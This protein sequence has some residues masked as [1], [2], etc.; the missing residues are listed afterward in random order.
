VNCIL[1]VDIGTTSTKA[2][3]VHADGNVP[4]SYQVHHETQYPSPGYAEQDPAE[5]FKAV[6]TAIATVMKASNSKVTG[7]SFSCA[8]HGIMAVNAQGQ[9]LTPLI[10]WSDTRSTPQCKHIKADPLAVDIY[11]STGTPIHP[12]SPLC[13]VRWMSEQQPHLF[14]SSIKFVSAKEYIFYHL[15]GTW[16]IDYAVASATGLFDVHRLQWSPLAIAAARTSEAQ[17]STPIS[18]YQQFFLTSSAMAQELQV[19]IDTR[20]VIGASDGCLANWGSDVMSDDTL[21]ITIGT[22]G[23]VRTTSPHFRHDA[24]QRIFNYRLDEKH[25]VMGGATNN[26]SVLLNWFSQLFPSPEPLAERIAKAIAISPGADD[27]L[28]LPYV[29]GE[30]APIYEPYARGVFFGL[31]QHHSPDH[32]LRAVM[33][34]ICYEMK[35][36][37]EALEKNL[38]HKPQRIVASGGFTQSRSWVQLLADVLD[39]ELIL[40]HTFDASAL[41]AAK[42]GFTALHLPFQFQTAVG[43]HFQPTHAQAYRSAYQLFSAVTQSLLPHFSHLQQIIG[44]HKLNTAHNLPRTL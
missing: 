15:F 37:L 8:M 9:A 29:F 13:K 40:T 23:A 7:I 28:F 26:G 34:G 4:F 3:L 41:G 32:L 1:A 39:R 21:S 19:P 17:L 33:E 14:H 27:L 25:F 20:F 24:K 30:R 43:Q 36:I 44:E 35:S 16:V 11:A 5:I 6:K 12:M 22:S 18:P 10:I 38:P 2:L 42:M 31:A